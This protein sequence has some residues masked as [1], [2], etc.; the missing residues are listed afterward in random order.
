MRDST[1]HIGRE[2]RS[3]LRSNLGV[4]AIIILAHFLITL[5]AMPSIM[6]NRS[7]FYY[8]EQVRYLVSNNLS[9]SRS[10]MLI[11]T[12]PI[13]IILSIIY[14]VRNDL[15]RQLQYSVTPIT[16]TVTN[17]AMGFI[18]IMLITL[19]G[20][21]AECLARYIMLITSDI[22]FEGEI[23]N[24]FSVIAE[25]LIFSVIIVWLV[26]FA[27]ALLIGLILRRKYIYT[28][29]AAGGIAGMIIGISILQSEV[30]MSHR[31]VHETWF[32][33][34]MLVIISLII[35]AAYC[36]INIRVGVR[37]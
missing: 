20:F 13:S 1:V 29:I 26:Y 3:S 32:M 17:V 33:A 14:F 8:F 34:L 2:I 9:T 24:M 31:F 25:G 4:I 6:M 7:Y 21:V 28:F 36:F 22:I 10:L 37:K 11:P 19:T 16:N 30:D 18:F 15:K 27:F 12:I 35:T 5:F 23:L